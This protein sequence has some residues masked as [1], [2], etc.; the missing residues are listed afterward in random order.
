MASAAG[1]GHELFSPYFSTTHMEGSCRSECLGILI[2]FW[3]VFSSAWPRSQGV[4]GVRG[5]ARVHGESPHACEAGEPLQGQERS[6][7]LPQLQPIS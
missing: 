4:P 1:E 6:L 2:I 7:A 3:S 5:H